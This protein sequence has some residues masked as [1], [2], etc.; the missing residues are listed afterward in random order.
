MVLPRSTCTAIIMKYYL[1]K[2]E[3]IINAVTS[4]SALIN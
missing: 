2:I 1:R 3:T 4:K